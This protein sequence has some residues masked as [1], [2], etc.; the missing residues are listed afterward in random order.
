MTETAGFN[1]GKT[2]NAETIYL[3]GVKFV[4]V[5]GQWRKSVILPKDLAEGKKEGLHVPFTN[6]LVVWHRDRHRNCA[7]ISSNLARGA[8]RP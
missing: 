6:K 5:N 1:G 4:M 3:N 8:G 2:R 7:S